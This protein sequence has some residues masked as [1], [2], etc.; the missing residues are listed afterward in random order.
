MHDD[1]KKFFH[2]SECS[3]HES[4]LQH[5]K[6]QQKSIIARQKLD[7]LNYWR[8]IQLFFLVFVCLQAKWRRWDQNRVIIPFLGNVRCSFCARVKSSR[9][10]NVGRERDPLEAIKVFQLKPK[11]IVSEFPRGASIFPLHCLDL[12]T[13]WMLQFPISHY[14]WR[15]AKSTKLFHNFTI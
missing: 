8:N 1:C 14:C 7:K 4:Y 5:E 2:L 10:K 6:Q 3:V 11:I 9:Q 12:G 13:E 15:C